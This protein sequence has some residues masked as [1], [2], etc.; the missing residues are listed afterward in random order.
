MAPKRS[1][2]LSIGRIRFYCQALVLATVCL[3]GGEAFAQP[4]AKS[5]VIG[6]IHMPPHSIEDT[7]LPSFSRE[8]FTEAMASQGYTVDIRFFPWARAFEL[9][10]LGKVDAVW[11]SIREKE[12]E[13]WFQF[14]SP[15]LHTNYVLIKRR[16]LPLS[17]RRLEDAKPYLVGTLRGGITGSALDHAG[18][19]YRIEPN[20]SFGQNLQKLAAGRID[21]MTGERY[22]AAYLLKNEFAPFNDAVEILF[23]TIST[24][25]FYLM[26]SK[27]APDVGD[28]MQA[29]EKGLRTLRVNGRLAAL[30][31]R[32]GYDV[33]VALPKID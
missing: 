20:T 18:G 2:Q 12:R 4:P 3:A 8:V 22:N 13:A 11:P 32:H 9:G 21:L 31:R 28:K 17:F 7:A 15:V 33:G 23:P 26:F 14:G 27:N 16:D 6:T 19:E 1:V 5:L 24:I 10:K 25:S 29:F 30:L